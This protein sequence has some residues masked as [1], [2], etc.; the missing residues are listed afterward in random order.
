MTGRVHIEDLGTKDYKET[1]DLQESIFQDI[2]QRK[3][4]R[5]NADLDPKDPAPPDAP[6][7]ALPQSRMLWVEHP[8]VLTL[9]K[10]GEAANVVAP[11]EE[12]AISRV[13]R[14]PGHQ[15]TVDSEGLDKHIRL[16]N[17]QYDNMIHVIASIGHRSNMESLAYM[18]NTASNVSQ[19]R[20]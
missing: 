10:S 9:G 13:A 15:E 4:A 8:H 18:D 6:H 3:I 7:L 19:W 14:L 5:R 17:R 2:V 16:S 12:L 11:P 20:R 1:W